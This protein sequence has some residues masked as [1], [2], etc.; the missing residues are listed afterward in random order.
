[1][2][3]H[4]TPLIPSLSIKFL[5]NK[6]HPTLF[7]LQRCSAADEAWDGSDRKVGTAARTT[8]QTEGA[9]PVGVFCGGGGGQEEAID[10]MF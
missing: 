2:L 1:M 6:V 10:M 8:A 7:C 9:S 3:D 5:I 4:F